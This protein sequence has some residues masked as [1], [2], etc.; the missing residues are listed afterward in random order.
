MTGN[1]FRYLEI[2]RDWRETTPLY[3]DDVCDVGRSL[4]S[5]PRSQ[6][7]QVTVL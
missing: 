7:T 1:S 3:L 5:V 4:P 2:Q 6:G